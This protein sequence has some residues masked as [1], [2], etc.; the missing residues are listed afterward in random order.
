M[1]Q[2]VMIMRVR[3]PA[4]LVP[5]AQLLQVLRKVPAQAGKAEDPD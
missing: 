1:C 3:L 5:P 4:V 2:V